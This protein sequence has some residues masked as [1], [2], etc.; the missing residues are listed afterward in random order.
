VYL[1]SFLAKMYAPLR[2]LCLFVQ[3]C[4]SICVVAKEL[5]FSVRGFGCALFSFYRK[6]KPAGINRKKGTFL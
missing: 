5:R 4:D 1:F 2:M 3:D 6:T